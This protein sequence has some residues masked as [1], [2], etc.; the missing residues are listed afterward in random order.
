MTPQLA[1]LLASGKRRPDI[2]GHSPQAARVALGDDEERSAC[3]Y[4]R[5]VVPADQRGGSGLP[6][7][8]NE[9]LHED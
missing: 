2:D 7:P 5:H 1:R 3:M 9:D 4:P 6:E 8:A